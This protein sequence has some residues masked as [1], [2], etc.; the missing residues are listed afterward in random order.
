M[1]DFVTLRTERAQPTAAAPVIRYEEIAG[2]RY[3]IRTGSFQSAD[4]PGLC[5]EIS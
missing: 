5:R 1:D 2:E 3:G 4:G